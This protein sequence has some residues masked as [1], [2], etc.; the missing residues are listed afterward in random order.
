MPAWAL[1][2]STPAWL[3]RRRTVTPGSTGSRRETITGR[4]ASM[5]VT[6]GGAARGVPTARI[7]TFA[8]QA[9]KP[10]PDSGG[11]SLAPGCRF[12]PPFRRA[13][14]LLDARPQRRHQVVDAAARQDLGGGRPRRRRPAL[15]QPFQPLPVFIRI[16]LRL[17]R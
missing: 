9:D 17:E 12:G 14:R 10:D 15:D 3:M 11:L 1:R 16:P 6:V 7:R 13:T 8:P 4:T 2:S 5:S